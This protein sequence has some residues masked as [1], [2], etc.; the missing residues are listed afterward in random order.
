VNLVRKVAYDFGYV[1]VVLILFY[2]LTPFVV[3]IPGVG[4]SLAAAI[5]LILL[6]IVVILLYDAARLLY[7]EVAKGVHALTEKVASAVEESEK[8][9]KK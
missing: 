8:R 6:A 9:T 5:P 2:V 1:I 3:L 4:A 7:E